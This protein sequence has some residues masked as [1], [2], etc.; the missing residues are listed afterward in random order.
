MP[1]ERVERTPKTV[2]IREL[3]EHV[4]HLNAESTCDPEVRKGWNTFLEDILNAKKAYAG[5]GF[6]PNGEVPPGHLPGIVR[7]P[8]QD[9]E[10]PDDTRRYY[11]LHQKLKGG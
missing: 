1:L 6:L 9:P 8:R 11:Y 5:Y 3:V 2:S 7:R 4:N 10:F